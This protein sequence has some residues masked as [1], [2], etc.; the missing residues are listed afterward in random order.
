MDL[1]WAKT[2]SSPLESQYFSCVP[3]LLGDGQAMQYSFWSRLKTRTPVPRLPKRPPDN[4]LRDAMVATLAHQ[5]AESDISI[6]LQTAPVLMPVANTPLP[7]PT[8]PSPPV[9]PAT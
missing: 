4:Y 7:C 5:D 2:Q 3:Y 1:L 6:Q 9:P 8:R